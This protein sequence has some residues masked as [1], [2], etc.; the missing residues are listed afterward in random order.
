MG[1]PRRRQL[2]GVNAKPERVACPQLPRLHDRQVIDE[3]AVAAVKILDHHIAPLQID[4]RMPA[5]HIGPA[6]QDVDA[7]IGRAHV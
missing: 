1:R 3:G 6:Q 5:A 7:K 2:Q 4:T